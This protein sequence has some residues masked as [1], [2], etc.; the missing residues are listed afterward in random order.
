MA[1]TT[2]TRPIFHRAG[3][4]DKLVPLYI[5][6]KKLAYKGFVNE[7]TTKDRYYQIASIGDM[8]AA[9][10]VNELTEIP[11]DD[12]ATPF[13]QQLVPRGRKVKYKVSDEAYSRDPNGIYGDKRIA[14]LLGAAITKAMDTDASGFLNR[15]DDSTFLTTPDGIAIAST[16][17][18]NA[19]GTYSTRLSTDAPL[20]YGALEQALVELSQQTSHDGD[21][22]DFDSEVW[23][24]V[25]PALYPLAMRIWK[26]MNVNTNAN[27][28][29]NYGGNMIRGVIKLSRATSSTAW[30][31]VAAD[32][33]IKPFMMVHG[34]AVKTHNWYD[35][36]IDGHLWNIRKMWALGVAQ[37]RG[38]VWSPG[39]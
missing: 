3:L 10:L 8:A 28:E 36:N 30:M 34:S 6:N 18:L 21:P 22:M 7:I 35:G 39:Q 16:A 26:S 19:A 25:P 11:E 2:N 9:T 4:I 29:Y 13:L 24:L 1:D 15:A 31:I 20:S 27:R 17:H 14:S 38:Y 5:A 12:F 32:P 23:L 37:A 33:D